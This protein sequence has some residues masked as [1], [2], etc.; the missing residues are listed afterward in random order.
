MYNIGAIAATRGDVL[1]ARNIWTNLVT[2]YP[3]SGISNLAKE[4]LGKLK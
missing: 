2:N 4:S 1:K 3:N